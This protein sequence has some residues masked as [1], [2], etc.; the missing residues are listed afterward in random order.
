MEEWSIEK[1]QIGL[2]LD[3][4]SCEL[5]RTIEMT[6]SGI[7]I[8]PKDETNG[9]KEACNLQDILT[10]VYPPEHIIGCVVRAIT[11]KQNKLLIDRLESGVK[12]VEDLIAN[13]C[14]APDEYPD[15]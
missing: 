6:P 1:V 4:T 7:F 10:D 3:V 2:A 12:Y 9:R 5:D 15:L 13:R 11:Q 8:C 14:R